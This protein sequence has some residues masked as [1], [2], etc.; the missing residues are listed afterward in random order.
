MF[1]KEAKEKLQRAARAPRHPY[2]QF[3]P[4]LAASG[5]D[6]Q[7]VAEPG[8]ETS[9]EDDVVAVPN[10]PEDPLPRHPATRRESLQST[11]VPSEGSASSEEPLTKRL[12]AELEMET[13]EHR[14][15]SRWMLLHESRYQHAR[16][17]A[18][19]GDPD[20]RCRLRNV[21]R[22]GGRRHDNCMRCKCGPADGPPTLVAC[23]SDEFDM[24]KATAEEAKGFENSDHIEWNSVTGMRAVKVWRGKEAQELR[25]QYAGRILRSRM[26][27]RKK[28]M[29][30]VG[31]FKFKSR[32][33]VLG[34]DS[35]SLHTFAPTPQAEIINLFFQA[36]LNL[37]LGIVFG[38]VTSAF[39]QGKK[40]ARAAGRLFAEPCD[41]IDAEKGDLVELLVAVYG[42][43]DAPVCWA[44]VRVPLWR[45]WVPTV[46]PGPV[47]LL[48][49][50]P[51]RRSGPTHPSHDPPGGRRLQHCLA[52][53]LRG[54]T[55]GPA[56]EALRLRQ[57]AAGRGRLQR[58]T[59]EN[60]G[61]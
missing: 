26:V 54:G 40:L 46:P 22:S 34:F 41:G 10:A 1:E 12:R 28:P 9:L 15:P 37:K 20:L 17:R 33:C 13:I 21:R 52:P 38:D 50:G 48:E 30:G 7:P 23:R 47:S 58:A 59:S 8:A 43:E 39:C 61:R 60:H 36:A 35:E 27:R 16:R 56:P 5:H 29:P 11:T 24:R 42:L 6:L 44:T 25:K 3:A 19:G 49:A 2:Q 14:W 31:N 32:W 57:V 51:G 18:A 4:G 53:R 45:T 55:T